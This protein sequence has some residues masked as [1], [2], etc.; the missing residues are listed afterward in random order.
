MQLFML[1]GFIIRDFSLIVN[2]HGTNNRGNRKL[3]VVISSHTTFL[4]YSSQVFR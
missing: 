1:S 3:T 4:I 2:I